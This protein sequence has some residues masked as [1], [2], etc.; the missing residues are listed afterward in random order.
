MNSSNKSDLI[1]WKYLTPLVYSIIYY[2]VSRLNSS[3]EGLLLDSIGSFL[4]CLLR[5]VGVW[6]DIHVLFP[7]IELLKS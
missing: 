5:V 2:H 7:K 6:Q 3:F 1:P 4:A